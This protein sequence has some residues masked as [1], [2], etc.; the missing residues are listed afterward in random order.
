MSE[1][2][3][4]L[5]QIGSAMKGIHEVLVNQ[6]FEKHRLKYVFPDEDT[7]DEHGKP[8]LIFVCRCDEG[9]ERRAY[10]EH[11]RERYGNVASD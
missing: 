7:P 11:I 2:E 1:G 8:T 9:F 6:A 10:N 4:L 3:A 5:D